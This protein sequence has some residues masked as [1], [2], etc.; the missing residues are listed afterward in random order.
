MPNV[1]L[2]LDDALLQAARRYAHDHDTSLN[3]LIRQQLEQ[4]VAPPQPGW[5]D[6]LAA[7]VTECQGCSAATGRRW[8]RDELHGRGA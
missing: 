8:T 1:T 4:V 5:S 3:D 6:A 2:A 7:S